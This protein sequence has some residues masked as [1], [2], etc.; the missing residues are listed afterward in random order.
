MVPARTGVAAFSGGMAELRAGGGTGGATLPLAA[1]EE[2][3][4]FLAV[5]QPV[6]VGGD[7]SDLHGLE[8]E[9]HVSDCAGGDGGGSAGAADL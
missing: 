5:E 8:D 4:V 7:P 3:G 6:P 9:K 1:G 2:W